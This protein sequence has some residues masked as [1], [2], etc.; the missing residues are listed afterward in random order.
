MKILYLKI[1]FFFERNF[2]CNKNKNIIENFKNKMIL[3]ITEIINSLQ[4]FSFN[5]KT[6]MRYIQDIRPIVIVDEPQSVDNTPKTKEATASLNPLC[7]FRYS[8]TQREKINLLYHAKIYFH[9]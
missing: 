7:V 1:T 2:T 6:A 5:G 4:D 8:A 9:L 3:A